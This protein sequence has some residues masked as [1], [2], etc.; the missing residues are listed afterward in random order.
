MINFRTIILT[1]AAC[2]GLHAQCV[3]GGLAVVV[4]KNNPTDGLSMAQLRKLVLG[5]VHT[6]PD[7]S[8]VTL[9][10]TD[11]ESAIFKCLLTTVVRMSL[12]EYRKY[13]MSAEFRG[14]D[15]LRSKTVDSSPT[16]VKVVA[17]FNGAISVVEA[18][19]VAAAAGTVKVL[20]IN[21]KKPGEPG[22]P[23]P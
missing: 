22:Y 13:I 21:G 19:S 3:P 5:D 11:Q 8:N 18:N 4:P 12:P 9:V 6:W 15:P 17:G 14:D 20:S 2:A 23:L 7:K 16:A 10:A 1:L